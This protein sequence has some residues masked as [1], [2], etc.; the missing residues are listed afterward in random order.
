ML[1]EITILIIAILSVIVLFRAVKEF[2]PLIVNS[3]GALIVLFILNYFSFGI[4][5][6]IWSIL[7]VAVGG[8]AGLVLVVLLHFLG[9]AF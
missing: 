1:V 4:L 9:I 7:I 3:L 5:I 2:L 8:F 6:N